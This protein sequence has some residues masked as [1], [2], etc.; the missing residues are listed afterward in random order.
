MKKLLLTL[1]C[2]SLVVL[3]SYGQQTEKCA[4]HTK[5]NERL[6]SDANYAQAMG[7]AQ[8]LAKKNLNAPKEKSILTIPVVVHVVYKNAAQ[9][10]SLAQV[11]SQIDVLNTDYR[12]VNIASL[13]PDFDSLK[14]DIEVEFCLAT[15]DPTGN[16]TDGITRTSSTGGTFFGYFSPFNDDIKYDSLNGKNAWPTDKY[17]NL[18][19][20]E[21][22]PGL[23]GYAQFPGD[24]KVNADGVA[25]T[26][27]AFGT[28]GNVDP[29]SAQ[30]R[31]AT[32][33]VGH[34][35]GLYHIWG[36][37]DTCD[38]SDTIPD[39]PNATEASNQGCEITRNSCSNEDPFWGVHDPNDMVQNYM[40]YSSDSCMALFTKGQKA[41]MWSFL[42]TDPRR[43][44]LATSNGC[45]GLGVNEENQANF[46][47]YPNPSATSFVVE[48]FKDLGAIIIY[49]AFGQEVLDLETTGLKTTVNISE[50]EKGIY[51][52]K[53][54]EGNSTAVRF[55][56]L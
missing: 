25:I 50:L 37:E 32:H 53:A 55:V 54:K 1:T 17:L 26:T 49:N 14:A 6:A 31:T 3:T 11:Q 9:N 20:G 16:P 43:L 41:R 36:D 5:H 10:I 47:V 18:W 56:K 38:G 42:S 7:A 34:W 35:M 24:P 46:S 4:T 23:L 8:S 21:M 45:A 19:V 22:F 30:G 40:D 33:E 12:G 15:V 29:I 28:T 51:F 52:V 2:S 39:T 44:G 27:T 48:S 13:S